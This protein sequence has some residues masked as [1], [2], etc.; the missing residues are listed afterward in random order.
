MIKAKFKIDG[1]HCTS[2]AFSIDGELEDTKGVKSAATNYAK[3]LTIVE[4]DEKLVETKQLQKAI[5]KLG[6]TSSVIE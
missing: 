5:E 1:M 4:F 3:Q 2:C 6:Y